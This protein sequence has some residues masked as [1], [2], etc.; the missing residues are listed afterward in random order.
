MLARKV[1]GPLPGRTNVVASE[2]TIVPLVEHYVTA[3]PG[4]TYIC[5][6]DSGSGKTTAAM[7]LLHGDY[8]LRPRRGILIRAAD[9]PDIA[10]TFARSV[11]APDA[12]P[13][14]HA[15]LVRALV[16]KELRWVTRKTTGR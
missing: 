14:I 1:F 6:G 11:H 10:T 16:P 15:L 2:S 7:Y 13:D 12:A 5:C 8:N 3:L 9:S 4:K